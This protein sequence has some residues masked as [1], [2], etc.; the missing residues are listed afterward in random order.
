MTTTTEQPAT[1]QPPAGDT[2]PPSSEPTLTDTADAGD[3]GD[4]GRKNREA[5][6]YRARLRDAEAERDRL[7]A[8]LDDAETRDNER[9]RAD[10]LAAVSGDTGVPAEL[11]VGDDDEQLRAHAEQLLTWARTVGAQA[12]RESLVATMAGSQATPLAPKAQ[13]SAVLNPNNRT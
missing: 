8:E 1:E 11:L 6:Q 10:L 2:A 5:A 12:R 4:G 3:N 7:A 13:W 9:A